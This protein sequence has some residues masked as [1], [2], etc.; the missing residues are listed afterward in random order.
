MFTELVPM[1]VVIGGSDSPGAVQSSQMFVDGL[2]GYGFDIQYEVMP[3]VG[4]TVTKEGVNLTID[5]FRKTIG[6]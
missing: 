4:H 5:L 6:K 3:G 2:K 1:L